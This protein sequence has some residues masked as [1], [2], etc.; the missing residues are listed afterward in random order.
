MDEEALN[1]KPDMTL[2]YLAKQDLYD[3]SVSDLEE[4]ISALKMEITRCE[5]TLGD[6]GSSKS[7]ADKLFKF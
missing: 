1:E 3:L 7:E 4:R 5:K 6:R 2:G